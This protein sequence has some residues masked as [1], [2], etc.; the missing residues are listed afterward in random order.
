M[1]VKDPNFWGQ[2]GESIGG[3]GAGVLQGWIEAKEKERQTQKLQSL[4]QSLSAEYQIPEGVLKSLDLKNL[5]SIATAQVKEAPKRARERETALTEATQSLE[6]IAEA[7]KLY[8]ETSVLDPLKATNKTAE[9]EG[10]LK[11]LSTDSTLKK[12]G[13]VI[14]KKNIGAAVP[15]ILNQASNAIRNEF[16]MRRPELPPE[17][18]QPQPQQMQPG[19][20]APQE[21]QAAP[22][23]PNLPQEQQQREHGMPDPRGVPSSLAAGFAG[24]PKKGLD[25]V[26]SLAN[27]LQMPGKMI[28]DKLGMVPEEMREDYM[29]PTQTPFNRFLQEQLP[30]REGTEAA[31]P[32]GDREGETLETEAV[33]D[34]AGDIG[35]QLGFA[36]M[37]GGVGPALQ[38]LGTALKAAGIVQ[39]AGNLASYLTKSLGYGDETARNAKTGLTLLTAY[40]MSP[41]F[42]SMSKNVYKKR[43]AAIPPNLL[44]EDPKVI[45]KINDTIT[46]FGSGGSGFGAETDAM[47]RLSNNKKTF[48]D[49][50]DFLSELHIKDMR[51]EVSQS[52]ITSF[53][54]ELLNA[55]KTQPSVPRSVVKYTNEASQ[56][57][58]AYKASEKATDFLKKIPIIGRYGKLDGLGGIGMFGLGAM[59]GNKAMM[60]G[61]GTAVIA[62]QTAK[63]YTGLKFLKFPVIQQAYKTMMYQAAIANPYAAG[64]AADRVD[65]L[66]RSYAEPK[67]KK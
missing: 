24:A 1:R 10:F 45:S 14:P 52:W 3:A 50:F 17:Q 32:Q 61:A 22:Y 33:R 21:Q 34:V 64:K 63:F 41:S 28:A 39:G 40:G 29:Q 19:G 5:Q 56:L 13:V 25:L 47:R 31:L 54:D 35:E 8:Q 62:G 51:S 4:Q 49:A 55:V 23:D 9:L 48:T 57:Y 37:T 30:T 46:Y 65:K 27:I 66:I 26:N 18:G 20:I 16:G 59:V 7:Q 38:G 67:K 6:K 44:I 42:Q 12:L 43:D 53:K 11:N 60:V 2:L 58:S 36:V 15:A